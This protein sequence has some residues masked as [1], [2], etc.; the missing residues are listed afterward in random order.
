MTDTVHTVLS[1]SL[2]FISHLWGYTR[3]SKETR[4]QAMRDTLQAFI[5]LGLLQTVYLDEEEEEID[6]E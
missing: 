1:V 4:V 3:G 6:D 2:L 5:D